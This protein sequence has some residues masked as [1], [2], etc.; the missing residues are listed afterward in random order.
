MST[1]RELWNNVKLVLEQRQVDDRTILLVKEKFF[2]S[3]L[4]FPIPASRQF[5][6]TRIEEFTH[7]KILNRMKYYEMVY[8]ANFPIR[9][10]YEYRVVN[11]LPRNAEGKRVLVVIGAPAGQDTKCIKDEIFDL[12]WDAFYAKHEDW[13]I[14]KLEDLDLRVFD[15]ENPPTERVLMSERYADIK[16]YRKSYV[17]LP[18][19]KKTKES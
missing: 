5:T 16:M 3:I 8:P 1:H 10:D 4:G 2:P 6:A 18:K 9:D 11:G 17:Y 15:P 14:V 12:G 13:D 19:V 7:L